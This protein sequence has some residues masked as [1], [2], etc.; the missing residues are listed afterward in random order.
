MTYR[1]SA[2]DVVRA[3]ETFTITL[4]IGAGSAATLGTATKFMLTLSDTDDPVLPASSYSLTFFR[5]F[6]VSQAYSVSNIK[7]NGRV[8]V[9]RTGTMP[10]GIRLAYDTR[11][12]RLVFSGSPSRV[13]TFEF[14]VSLSEQRSSGVATGKVTTFKVTVSDPRTLK[15][16]DAGYNAVLTAGSTVFGSVPLYGSLSGSKMVAGVA[17]VKVLRSGRTTVAYIG[18]DGARLTLSGLPTLSSD[19]TMQFAA[20]RGDV[21]ATLKVTS[22]GRATLSMTGISTRFGSSLSSESSGIALINAN[23]AAYAGY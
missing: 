7:E 6:A 21:N 14:G 12:K 1:I 18:S 19:G 10:T 20:S 23:R 17:T 4:A 11:T 22:A 5:K 16:G 13:G 8:T 15:P 3:D 9:N 2:D